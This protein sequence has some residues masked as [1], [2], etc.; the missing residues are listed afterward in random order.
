MG[1]L[2]A[3]DPFAARRLGAAYASRR[4]AEALEGFLA[5][6][7]KDWRPLIYCWRGG[8]RSGSMAHVLAKVGWRV[9]ILEGGYR[10]FRRTVVAQLPELC[11]RVDLRVV[12]GLTGTG[13]TR[14]LQ[15]LARSGHQVLDLEGIARHRGSILGADPM[16][17]Q[18]SQ[19]WFESQLWEALQAFDP[20][21]PVFVESES[22][23]VGNVQ[24]PEALI[25]RM[26]AGPCLEVMLPLEDR[27]ALLCEDYDYFRADPAPL[28]A[29]LKKLHALVGAERLEGWLDLVEQSRW[30]EFVADMLV[31]H[32]DPSYARSMARNFSQWETRNTIALTGIDAESM[33]A[34]ANAAAQAGS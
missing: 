34:W 11:A 5:A 13:K 18:P 33:M 16:A 7:P 31:H 28:V 23:K 14:L 2:H 15:T 6:K 29:Q 10:S 3:S 8:N 21:R 4:I 17:P 30:S 24:V 12:C 20:H 9:S 27:V 1:T 25:Q 19:K 32:Y 26:R 22:R